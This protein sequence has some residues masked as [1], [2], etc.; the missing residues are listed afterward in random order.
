MILRYFGFSEDPFEATPDPR[1]LYNSPSHQE[2]LA[3]LMYGFHSNRGFT[4]LIAPPG[5]GKTT[6]LFRFLDEI[7]ASARTVFLFD[8]L[9]EPL[10]LVRAML[11][12]LRIIPAPNGVEMREQLKDIVVSEARAGRRFVVVIDEAQNMSDDALEMVRLL[13]NFETYRAKLIQVVLCGQPKLS[14]KLMQ[15]SLEQLRQRIATYCQLEPLSEEQT[16]AYID[17]RLK[18][19][20]YAGPSLFTNEAMKLIAQASHGIPRTI[21]NL[22]FNALSLCCAMGHKQVDVGIVSEAITDQRLGPL[23]ID[24][25]QGSIASTTESDDESHPR[26]ISKGLTRIGIAA[27]LLLVAGSVLGALALLNPNSLRSRGISP[28][29]SSGRDLQSSSS[30]TSVSDAIAARPALRMATPFSVIVGP[31]QSLRDISV[32]YLGGFDEARQHQ[33][34]SLNPKMKDPGH[35]ESGQTLWLPGQTNLAVTSDS[36]VERVSPY[37]IQPPTVEDHSTAYRDTPSANVRSFE[38][39]VGPDQTLHDVCIQHLGNFDLQRLHQVESLNP[40]MTDPDHIE[41]G[42]KLR[43][44]G[45]PTELATQNL[46]SAANARNTN[47]P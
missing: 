19:A 3:S 27:V 42:Q 5:L 26:G 46:K 17:H 40:K 39:T 15:P 38:V 44:P 22:C 25:V 35:I 6:L 4:A 14:E 43:L 7:N 31:N 18:R 23:L 8:S 28:Q 29:S 1:S 47:E 9:C 34:E 13:T 41:A 10:E 33:I 16:A 11:R 32:Q 2:A 36:S 30:V 20:A 37:A 45:S 21:N 24:S 12:D